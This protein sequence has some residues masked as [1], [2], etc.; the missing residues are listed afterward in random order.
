MTVDYLNNKHEDL[1]SNGYDLVM[2]GIEVA[3]GSIRIH[4]SDVQAKVFELFG[5]INLRGYERCFACWA[6]G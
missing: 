5:L 1:L 2:N 4:K 6:Q 3:G